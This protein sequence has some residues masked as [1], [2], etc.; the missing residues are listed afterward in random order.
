MI[1]RS[2]V[3][4]A[5]SSSG[6]RLSAIHALVRIQREQKTYVNALEYINTA[7][8]DKKSRC[9]RLMDN[10]DVS[11]ALIYP[12]DILQKIHTFSAP[13][14]HT[15]QLPNASLGLLLRIMCNLRDAIKVTP[16]SHADVNINQ[17]LFL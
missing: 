7:V 15:N 2:C 11:R 6:H 10:F 4:I 17:V 1:S 8:D 13:Q 14:P 3:P 12:T 9:D 5:I 16:T